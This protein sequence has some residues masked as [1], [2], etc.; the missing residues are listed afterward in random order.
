MNN[1]TAPSVAPSVAD[2][3]KITVAM[4]V[5]NE[6]AYLSEA[7][8]SIVNQQF[9][10]FELIIFDNASTDG[11]QQILQEYADRDSR[12]DYR[13]LDSKVGVYSNLQRAIDD[14]RGEYF[15]VA[16]GHDRH[17]LNFLRLC[18]DALDEDAFAVSAVAR[19]VWIDTSSDPTEFQTGMLDTTGY[20][21]VNRFI[22]AIWMDH[23]CMYGL[24]RISRLRE[25]SY[26][27]AGMTTETLIVQELAARGSTRAIPDAQWYRRVIR[28]PESAEK[29]IERY[30]A[31][32]FTTKPRIPILP[33]WQIP[34]AVFICALRSPVSW[35]SR[36]VMAISSL[37]IFLYLREELVTD[38]RC[39]PKR[40]W[41]FL[42]RAVLRK[43]F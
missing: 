17:S 19:A 2:A 29:R 24:H 37:T 43:K 33:C 22:L 20:H 27:K 4:F 13:R 41:R 9:Q 25:T 12:I 38:I 1:S 11:S 10:D 36:V 16:A 14:A 34:F 32:T 3:P 6:A 26:K 40:L 31:E 28:P 42:S 23:N 39:L 35:R 21:E 8:E 15:A 30:Y 7:M 18:N 5:H